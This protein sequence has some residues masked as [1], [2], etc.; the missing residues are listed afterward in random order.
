[1]YLEL[2]KLKPRRSE[3]MPVAP[4]GEGKFYDPIHQKSPKL[5]EGWCRVGEHTAL[6]L[7]EET[8]NKWEIK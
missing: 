3:P 7:S 8:C 4:C 2:K 6:V 1:M 5:S